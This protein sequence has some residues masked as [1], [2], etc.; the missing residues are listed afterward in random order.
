MAIALLTDHEGAPGGQE[1]GIELASI[2]P[3]VDHPDTAAITGLG[4][5]RHRCLQLGVLAD[6]VRCRLRVEGAH[7]RHDRGVLI[8]TATTWRSQ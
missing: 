5:R 8:P 7:Q 4:D 2:T 1:V 6:E 3:A